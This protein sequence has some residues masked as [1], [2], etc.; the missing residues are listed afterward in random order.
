MIIDKQIPFLKEIFAE[1]KE[2]IESGKW[3]VEEADRFM[4]SIWQPSEYP[5]W[6]EW[7]DKVRLRQ[8]DGQ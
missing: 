7:L 4:L 8:K 2:T 1:W 6:P 3:T 5:A